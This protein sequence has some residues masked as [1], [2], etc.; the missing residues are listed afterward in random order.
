MPLFESTYTRRVP[1]A[2]A[3]FARLGKQLVRFKPRGKWLESELIG[4][5]KCRIELPLW[6]IR[7]R[8]ADGIWQRA[9]GTDGARPLPTAANEN[10]A[11]ATCVRLDMEG[12]TRSEIVTM[13]HGQA[14]KP[15]PPG[16][17]PTC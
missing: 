17:V 9:T 12:V 14:R 6:H 2:G 13:G 10:T 5:A 15:A 4:N 16:F 1:E 3:T 7:Y 11:R 8:D